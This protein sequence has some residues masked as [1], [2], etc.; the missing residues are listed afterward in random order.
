MIVGLW[1]I[2]LWHPGATLLT[3][4]LSVRTDIRADT[5][6]VGAL[7]A[8]VWATYDLPAR[9]LRV[10]AYVGAAILIT[11]IAE[12]PSWQGFLYKGGF[13]LIAAAVATIILATVENAWAGCR[14]LQWS[15]LRA[16]G[17]VSY[18]IYLWHFPLFV[19]VHR[20]GRTWPS[21]MQLLLALAATT[22]ATS[23]SWHYV[24]RPFL[25]RKER[26]RVDTAPDPDSNA[27]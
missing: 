24:E 19:A 25:L 2:H 16:T 11:C 18:G 15:S 26:R 6:L 7:A 20:Y 14:I 3:D 12:V 22:V 9:L 13:T 10:G 8:H 27:S 21:V 17:R 5:L 1:R 23:A 4:P